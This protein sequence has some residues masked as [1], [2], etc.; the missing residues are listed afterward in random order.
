MKKHIFATV[1]LTA[2]LLAFSTP[3]PQSKPFLIT[4]KMPH[5]TKM[6]MQKWNDPELA[7]TQTQKA[8]LERVRKET[9]SAIAQIKPQLSKLEREIAEKILR[10][11]KPQTLKAAV[12]KVA[13][14]KTKATMAHLKCIHDTQKILTP[15]QLSY[16]RNK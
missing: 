16:L 14:L 10:G 6:V 3:R 8:A 2:S 4:G 1:F 9:M 13:K 7:L 15:T 5:Y 12:E 11:E